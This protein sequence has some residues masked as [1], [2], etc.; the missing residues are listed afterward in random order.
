M[1]TAH[2]S[3]TELLMIWVVLIAACLGFWAIIGMALIR[4]LDSIGAISW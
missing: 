2:V 1:N 4:V 3:A